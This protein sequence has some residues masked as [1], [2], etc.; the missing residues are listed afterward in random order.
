M[1]AMLCD[2]PSDISFIK[3]EVSFKTAEIC[4]QFPAR[5]RISWELG[6]Q[7]PEEN[8][9]LLKRPKGAKHVCYFSSIKHLLTKFFALT[10]LYLSEC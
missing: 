9:A 7:V 8:P 1:V 3:Q 2:L 5:Q 4:S 10:Q 6:S